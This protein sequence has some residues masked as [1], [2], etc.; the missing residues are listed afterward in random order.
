MTYKWLLQNDYNKIA[1]K[2]P[3]IYHKRYRYDCIC[4]RVRVCM[5]VHGQ[6][7][8]MKEEEWQMAMHNKC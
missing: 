6:T 1:W 4:V 8:Q 3:F 7:P 2:N 5:I